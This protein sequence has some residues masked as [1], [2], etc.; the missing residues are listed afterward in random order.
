MGRW[1][2][3]PSNKTNAFRPVFFGIRHRVGVC[4]EAS[5]LGVVIGMLHLESETRIDALYT[6]DLDRVRK[7]MQEDV[8]AA[9]GVGLIA[10]QILFRSARDRNRHCCRPDPT[11]ALIEF[12]VERNQRFVFR[13]VRRCL[14]RVDDGNAGLNVDEPLPHC[15]RASLRPIPSTRP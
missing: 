10:E 3:R 14:A 6:E 9:I 15:Y 2:S 13:D 7:L 4:P 11:R 1:P 8:L 12:G 5:R